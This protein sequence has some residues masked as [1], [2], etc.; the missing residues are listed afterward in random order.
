[1]YPSKA[2]PYVFF[3]LQGFSMLGSRMTSIAIGLKL[4]HETGQSTPLLL[5]ALFNELPLLFLGGWIGI[6]ADRWKRK[7]AII[8]GDT[9]QAVCT[10]LL[11]ICLMNIHS[12]LWPVYVIAAVQGFFVALQS[13]AT[14]AM[15]PLMVR[16]EELDRINAMK[17]LLFPLAGVIAPSL[18]GLLY[19]PYG[20][21][22]ILAADLFTFLIGTGV[23]AFLPLPEMK[24]EER[25]LEKIRIWNDAIQGFRF[26][27]QNKPLLYLLLYFGWWNFIL[28]GPLELAIPFFL[29]RTG[30]SDALTLLLGAMN[31]GALAGAAAAVWWGHFRYKIRFI[32]SGSILTS[33]MFVLLGTSTHVIVLGAAVFLLMLPLAMTG[34][35]FYSILQRKTPLS[36]Q[37]RVFAAYGQLCALMAPMSFLIT[38]PMAD[39]WLER[40]LLGTKLSP[41]LTWIIGSENAT[42]IG[43]IF[44]VSGLL[45]LLGTM[46]TLLSRQVRRLDSDI[47]L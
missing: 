30:S 37:G 35:L 14:S 4:F 42:S 40:F 17:E 16:D 39:Q 24:H 6:A 31:A 10:L 13:T 8:A 33:L 7:T 28:N 38:G 47:D 5:L 12:T 11:V 20:I 21:S 9:G 3:G 27:W 22:I 32:F 25:P 1:M 43:L 26:L 19:E 18:T 23:V 46:W 44:I 34:A 36:L 45:L 15:I 41:W 2:L 29:Q